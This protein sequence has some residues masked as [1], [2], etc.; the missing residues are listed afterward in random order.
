[1]MKVCIHKIILPGPFGD[2]PNFQAH[3]L[4]WGHWG[5]EYGSIQVKTGVKTVGKPG[6]GK[7]EG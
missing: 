6:D 3:K 2:P 7:T 4:W 1:M 5:R